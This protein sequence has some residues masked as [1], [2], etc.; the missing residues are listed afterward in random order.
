MKMFDDFKQ[1]VFD[2]DASDYYYW[3]FGPMCEEEYNQ[4]IAKGESVEAHAYE[5]PSWL[6][7][8][9][10]FENIMGVLWLRLSWHLG[11]VLCRFFGH[12][13]VDVQEGS[14]EN[15]WVSWSCPRCGDGGTSW[16]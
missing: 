16:W 11:A 9:L 1:H 6:K 15:P 8:Q 7:H 5:M 3:H 4:A 13:N 14:A 10:H 12:T 2:W